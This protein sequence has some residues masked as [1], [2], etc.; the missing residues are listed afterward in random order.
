MWRTDCTKNKTQLIQRHGAQT[1]W[2][3]ELRRYLME[4][5]Q[6]LLSG[7]GLEVSVEDVWDHEAR[8][9]GFGAHGGRRRRRD[10][11]QD[12]LQTTTIQLL[13]RRHIYRDNHSQSKHT[14]PDQ[15]HR[16]TVSLTGQ[17]GRGDALRGALLIVGLRRSLRSRGALGFRRHDSPGSTS[18]RSVCTAEGSSLTWC[19]TPSV[20][21]KQQVIEY[22]I[23]FVASHHHNTVKW[24]SVCVWVW[25]SLCACVSLSPGACVIESLCVCV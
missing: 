15:T 19:T 20:R 13:S 8:G 17:A 21:Q 12:L 16:R 1:D 10:A 14:S 5:A 2:E 23:N 24:V 22:V 11:G 18:A 25:G 4:G 9:P 3:T 7:V 6:N